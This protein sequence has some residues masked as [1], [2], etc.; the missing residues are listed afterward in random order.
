MPG[1]HSA[2]RFTWSC[3]AL[4]AMTMLYALHDAARHPIYNWDLIAYVGAVLQRDGDDAKTL[5][6]KTFAEVRRS[7]PPEDFARLIGPVARQKTFRKF[8]YTDPVA[9]MQQLPY[10]TVKPLYVS[11][12][13]AVARWSEGPVQAAHRVSLVA[14]ALL[15]VMLPFWWAS[16]T[17]R[18]LWML[19]LVPLLHLGTFPIRSVAAIATPDALSLLLLAVGF[20]LLLVRRAP[21]AGLTVL[22][23]SLA[24]RP[25]NAILAVLLL[26]YLT[27]WAP[28]S[29]RLHWRHTAGWIGAIVM[30]SWYIQWRHDAYPWSQ[31]VSRGVLEVAPYPADQAGA[32]VDGYLTLLRAGVQRMALEAPREIVMLLAGLFIFAASL[33]LSPEDRLHG[34][35]A[36]LGSISMAARILVYPQVAER[37]FYF[38]YLLIASAAVGVARA[39]RVHAALAT[40]VDGAIVS[41]HQREEGIEHG[42]T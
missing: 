34:G 39:Y 37:Y 9:F 16:G 22:M 40:H 11:M 25:D 17:G 13:A 6:Q 1:D 30:L 7:V 20:W 12:V 2:R 18:S 41:P 8:V 27:V 4:Y 32:G 29:F 28:P 26:V 5:H 36:L 42:R 23:L 38:N 3:L 35:V 31:L 14:F 33:R 21:H 10:Y 24:A 15:A 19:V